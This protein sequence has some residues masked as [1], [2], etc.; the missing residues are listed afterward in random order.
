MTVTCTCNCFPSIHCRSVFHASMRRAVFYGLYTWLIHTVFGLPV[1]ILPS[2]RASVARAMPLI[3][4][5]PYCLQVG[6][7]CVAQWLKPMGG[8]PK[9]CGFD[10]CLSLDF[11]TTLSE[12]IKQYRRTVFNCEC[13]IIVNCKVSFYSCKERYFYIRACANLTWMQ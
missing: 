2:G 12:G 7:Q 3:S 4:Q 8:Y 13:L 11:S 1:S 10:S 5:S 6:P 9:G